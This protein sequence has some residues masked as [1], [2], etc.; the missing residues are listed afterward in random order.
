MEK[1]NQSNLDSK[2][3]KFFL[4]SIINDSEWIAVLDGIVEQCIDLLP[5]YKKVLQQLYHV[6]DEECDIRYQAFLTCMTLSTPKVIILYKIEESKYFEHFP[7]YAKRN[8]AF[9]ISGSKIIK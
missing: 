5:Y 9:E 7:L 2:N 4:K 1:Y 3:F 8:K 6:K